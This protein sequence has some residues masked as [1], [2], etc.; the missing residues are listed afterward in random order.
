MEKGRRARGP[1]GGKRDKPLSNMAM[2]AVLKRMGRA[3]LT[4]QGFRSPFR[5]WAAERTNFP[6][7]V[8]EMALAHIVGDKVEAA[9]RRG[10]LFEKRRRL[11]DAWVEYLASPV[12]PAEVVSLR[13]RK[14]RT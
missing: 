1:V 7:E 8:V 5:D 10:D 13:G 14:A 9:Y 12:V 2:A 6:N 11:M 4:V 3:D